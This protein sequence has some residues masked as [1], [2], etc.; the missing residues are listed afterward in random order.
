MAGGEDW[1]EVKSGA[2]YSWTFGAPGV[3]GLGAGCSVKL[4]GATPVPLCP[5]LPMAPG[6]KELFP[7]LPASQGQRANAAVGLPLLPPTLVWRERNRT[8]GA[9]VHP[10]GLL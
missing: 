10:L 8:E 3:W 2:G 5:H 1:R 4:Q 9:G 7:E 6:S